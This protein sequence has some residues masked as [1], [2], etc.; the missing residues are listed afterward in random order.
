MIPFTT[1]FVGYEGQMLEFVTRFPRSIRA[2][3]ITDHYFQP[4]AF[5]KPLELWHGDTK[6]DC[7]RLVGRM[8]NLLLKSATPPA[9]HQLCSPEKSPPE[10]PP[11]LTPRE[12]YDLGMR[13][14][15]AWHGKLRCYCY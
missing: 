10:V 8:K 13:C 4:F 11:F 15:P 7:D 9:H 3:N 6:L 1:I 5:G 12:A 2:H 14:Q